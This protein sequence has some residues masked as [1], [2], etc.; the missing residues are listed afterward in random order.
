MCIFWS[1]P[2][3]LAFKLSQSWPHQVSVHGIGYSGICK[4]E[5]R[6]TVK[7]EHVMLF[8]GGGRSQRRRNASA[9]GAW[10]QVFRTSSEEDKL[11]TKTVCFVTRI[12]AKHFCD[13]ARHLSV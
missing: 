11:T 10:L 1:K 13:P 8:V 4:P 5:R 6:Y 12:T 7:L 3:V 2:L 9:T